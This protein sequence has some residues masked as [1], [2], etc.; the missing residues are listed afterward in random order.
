[1][2]II[3]HNEIFDLNKVGLVATLII[4]VFAMFYPVLMG[5][6]LLIELF[7]GVYGYYLFTQIHLNKS[8]SVYINSENQWFSEIDK[9]MIPLE[10]KD[11]WLQTDRLFIWLKGSKK[12]V[13]FVVSR[14]IIGAQ[15]FSQLKTKIQAL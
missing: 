15:K 3:K 2:L 7:L 5:I 11:Y 12:S 8:L 6:K 4:A 9:E 14:S 13:S 1:M 10:L